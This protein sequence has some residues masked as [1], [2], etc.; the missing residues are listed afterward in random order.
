MTEQLDKTST[1]VSALFTAN[2]RMMTEQIDQTA[3]EMTNSFA[4]TAVRVTKQVN[5]VNSMMVQRL[6]RASSEVSTQLNS[7]GSSMFAKIDETSRDLGQRFDVATHLLERV[8]GDISGKLEGTSTKFAEIID[9]ASTQIITDL[10]KASDAL[11]EGLGQTTLQIT[12]RL[13]QDSG[14]LIDRID[15]AARGL[16]QASVDTAV[17][18]DEANRKFSK[19]VETANTYL[20]D[21]LATAAGTLDERL[22]TVSMQ[23]TGKLELTSSRVSERL[24][25]VTLLVE[26]SLDKFN[27]EME[28][29]LTNRK[30]ALDDLIGDASKRATE[31]DAVMTSYMSLIEDSLS[32]SE[33]RAKDVGRIIAE[34]TTL[35]KRNLEEEINKL[36]AS[37]G[38]QIS[39]AARVLRDQ[40][41]RAMATMNEM[42]SSTATDFQQTAQDMRITAQQVVKDIDS[43]RNELKR[44]I[45][46]LPEET[47][48]NA[49]AMRRVVAD[50][51][52][53]LSALADVV[54]RQT[55][56]LDISGPGVS[57][58]RTYRDPSPGKAEGAT[59]SIPQ[60]G[61]VSA[62]TKI[63]ARNND[64]AQ[65]PQLRGRIMDEPAA[66]AFKPPSMAQA[67]PELSKQ[68]ENLVQKLN[69]AARDLVDTVDGGLPRD[70]ERKFINGERDIYTHRIFEGLG[71]RMER[72]ITENYRNDR[73]VRSRVDSYIR[74]FERLL[75]TMTSSTK[76][77][78]L[79]EACLASESGRIYVMLAATAGRI[80]SQS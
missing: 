41:E 68:M 70:L 38:G 53:A 32:N 52:S 77:E 61:T 51:I 73:M 26:R 9:T 44:A 40:H 49:D 74:L 48:N 1:E 60:A 7:A 65:A 28:R 13:E 39:Q 14:L 12:G 69:D 62:P 46:D 16:E 80:P 11:S 20:A 3:S 23:L 72:T 31:I 57:L 43:A 37:S 50:Q 78:T 15:Q 30:T 5:E 56:S 4:D 22:D 36:E 66:Q 34:Q 67:L 63:T 35:A 45:L 18:L 71:K 75:D 19:H 21:Q 6:E 8:T 17:K 27:G 55:G 58:S 64:A 42:L 54:K 2:T 10:G 24:D 79:V 29:V 76:G 59:V 33:S 47:R 25:D